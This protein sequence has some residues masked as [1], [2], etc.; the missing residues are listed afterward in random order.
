MTSSRAGGLTSEPL[1]A[2]KVHKPHKGGRKPF[3]V[4]P[5]WGHVQLI[6]AAIG[7]P[8]FI[9]LLS[10]NYNWGKV[11]DYALYLRPS[12]HFDYLYISWF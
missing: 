11:G 7:N 9:G 4:I 6:R 12:F 3:T 8:G 5:R 10:I 2:V 1:K